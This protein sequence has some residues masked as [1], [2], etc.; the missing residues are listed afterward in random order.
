MLSVEILEF[1][2]PGVQPLSFARE[3]REKNRSPR[4]TM[5]STLSRTFFKIKDQISEKNELG[6]NFL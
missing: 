3:W 5:I 1:Q 6:L 4:D 2:L